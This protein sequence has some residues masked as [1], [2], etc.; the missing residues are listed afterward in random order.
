MQNSSQDQ[1][2]VSKGNPQARSFA[3][4]EIV[5]RMRK[6][7]DK[8]LRSWF[9]QMSKEDPK[10]AGIGNYVRIYSQIPQHFLGIIRYTFCL[11]FVGK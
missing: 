5:V 7:P 3:E 10:S 8:L 1:K 11:K 9:I 6:F 2:A 4:L